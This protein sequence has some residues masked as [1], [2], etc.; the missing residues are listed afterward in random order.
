VSPRVL[1]LVSEYDHSNFP[2]GGIFFR[3]QAQALNAAGTRL[4]VVFVEPRSLRT[5]SP[6]ALAESHFQVREGREGAVF[7]MR[8][9]GWNTN[10]RSVRGGRLGA[11]L[12]RRLAERY[13][14]VHGRP[15]L[16]HAQN[17][18]WAGHAA[19][20][21]ARR[22][23]I[24]YVLTEHF[25]GIHGH[26]I[27]PTA[28]VFVREAYAG[29]ARL[30]AVSRS[31]A[32]AMGAYTD[33]EV[34][35]V[36]NL[37]DETWFT[38]PPEEPPA[39][40]WTLL[41]VGGLN[42]NKNFSLLLRAWAAAFGSAPS[43]RLRIG[44]DG[45][46]RSVLPAL[47]EELEI[48]QR[49]EFLGHLSRQA[50]REALWRSHALALTSRSETF[51]IVLIEALATGRPVVATRCGGAED[52]VT[53]ENG[54]LVASDDVEALAAAL[55][56]V[57]ATP[58]GPAKAIRSGAVDRFGAPAVAARL[59]AVYEQALREEALRSAATAGS[60]GARPATA[61]KGARP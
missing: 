4:D 53:P 35:V 38:L 18:L 57:R 21:L 51:G 36:P 20:G 14:R 27:R 24:P 7:T 11:W 43:C 10:V 9:M 33:R 16:V 19:A 41:A 1:M 8:R 49:V 61:D 56:T 22:H 54:L 28:G 3:D 47:A 46:L 26:Q 6:A 60:D 55:R 59:L 40:P 2:L 58:P 12:T 17:A 25:S 32:R 42:E 5:L 15:D 52:I 13:L 48:G 23:G 37:V 44:G 45:P 31:L 50:M 39:I 29:A 34:E 30:L